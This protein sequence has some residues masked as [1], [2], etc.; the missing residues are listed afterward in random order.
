MEIRKSTPDDIPEI[1]RIFD[2][3][4]AYMA[5]HGNHSQWGDGYP[6][7]D[8]LRKDMMSGNHYVMLDHGTIVGTFSLIIGEEPTYQ[9]IKDGAWH[10][11]KTYGT[12]HRLASNG[13]SRGIARSCFEFCSGLTDY[14]RIDTHMDN[15]SMRAAIETYGFRKCGTI[16]VRNG[17]ERI[18]YDYLKAEA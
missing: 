17:S 11:D 1:L 3:A 15:R 18:A 10:Y 4:R 13:K 12:I 14:L 8:V 2:I 6:G 9:V 16:F 5:A 7:E